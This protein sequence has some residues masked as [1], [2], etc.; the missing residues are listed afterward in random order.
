VR[1][2]ENKCTYANT[3]AIIGLLMFTAAWIN[4]KVSPAIAATSMSDKC[5]GNRKR[6]PR[7]QTQ[8]NG[9]PIEALVDSGALVSVMSK[10]AFKTVWKHCNMQRL[11]I[12]AALTVS[13][14]NGEKIDVTG[15]V[16]IPLTIKDEKTDEVRSFTRPVLV[17]SGI[18]QTDLILGYDFIQEEGMVIDGA[19]N[20]T[21]FA[22]RRAEG[23]DTWWSASPCCLRRTTILPK[24]ITHAVLGTVTQGG[25]HV[26]AG[27]VGLCTAIHGSALGIWDSACTV[28]EHGQLVIAIVNMTNDMFNLVSGDCVGSMSNSVFEADGGICKLNDESVNTIFGNISKVPEDPKWGEGPPIEPKEKKRLKERLQVLPEEPWRQQYIDLMLRYHDVCS[29][30]KFDLGCADVIKHSIV[31]EDKRT[32]HQRQFRVPFAHEEVQYENVDKLF[33]LGAIEVS[34]SLY[35]SAVFCVVKKQLPNAAPGDPVPLRVVLDFRAVNLKSLPGV[36]GR[37]RQGQVGHIL[38]VRFNFGFL[39][40]VSPGE[41]QAVHGLLCAGQGSQ[42]PVEGHADGITGLAGILRKTDGFRHDGG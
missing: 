27:A 29:K 32:V 42:V 20:E 6:R 10:K 7:V 39:A 1:E 33:K 41:E 16:E 31:M 40:A 25:D 22:D 23:G 11:P 14:V 13:G 37:G 30:D 36:L 8:V 9:T 2:K 35:N 17:L 21:Y 15:Y 34:R 26:Q 5:K 12:P 18:G 19:A 28:D 38:D 3:N 24:T 4:V